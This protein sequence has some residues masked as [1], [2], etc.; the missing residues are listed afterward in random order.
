MKNHWPRLLQF[1]LWLGLFNVLVVFLPTCDWLISS[2]DMIM[3]S[4]LSYLLHVTVQL[5][6]L[7][8]QTVLHRC[9]CISLL[10]CIVRW[11]HSLIHTWNLFFST[12]SVQMPYNRFPW[13][14]NWFYYSFFIDTVTKSGGVETCLGSHCLSFLIYQKILNYIH[15]YWGKICAV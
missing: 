15:F 11:S 12:G 6:R 9:S 3:Y 2:L 13:I 8:S 7:W 5:S 10:L 1:A 4:A 14:D